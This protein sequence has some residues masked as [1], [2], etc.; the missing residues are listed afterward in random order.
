VS[1][2]QPQN[3]GTAKK[4][5]RGENLTESP[6]RVKSEC[7]LTEMIRPPKWSGDSTGPVIYKV[8]ISNICIDIFRVTYLED[9][10]IED[11]QN[12]VLEKSERVDFYG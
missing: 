10:K 3:A 2:Q 8:A 12:Y 7:T 5:G 1:S 6:K 9:K 11:D 4:R